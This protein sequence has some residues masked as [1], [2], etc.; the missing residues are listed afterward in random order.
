MA[1]IGL[2]GGIACGKTL[3]SDYIKK[4]GVDVIDADVITRR[5]YL[6]G[7]DLLRSIENEF[8][9]EYI[10]ADGNL[11]R[12][13]LR[14]FVF[15]NYERKNRLNEIVHPAIR[16]AVFR[17][18]MASREDHQM[19]VVPLLIEAGYLD[20]CDEVWVMRVDADTQKQRLM[21]RDGITEELAVSMIESQMPFEEK[22]KYADRV[23]D[24]RGAR[25]KTLKQVRKYFLKFLKKK[26]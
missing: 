16:K 9:S 8:G 4:Y 19:I 23:I 3:V 25:K 6:P 10:L 5:L 24:N 21:M 7:S 1:V 26:C 18:L 22:L 20:L 15:D 2:T 11:D 14:E 17:D 12:A 13:A